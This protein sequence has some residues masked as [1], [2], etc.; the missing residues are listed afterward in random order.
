MRMRVMMMTTIS[1]NIVVRIRKLGC[2]R[3]C[4][5]WIV[6]IRRLRVEWFDIADRIRIGRN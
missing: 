3:I 5:F 6:I 1:I 4:V 2:V